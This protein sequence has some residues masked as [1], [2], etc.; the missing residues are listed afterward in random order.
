V[1]TD[2][3]VAGAA[4]KPQRCASELH[5]PYVA[6][7]TTF[8]FTLTVTDG[9]GARA[10]DSVAITVEPQSNPCDTRPPLLTNRHDGRR[11]ARVSRPNETASVYFRVIGVGTLESGGIPTSDWQIYL[12]LEC[13]VVVRSE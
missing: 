11:G 1:G 9:Y 6:A 7:P 13:Q 3:R 5:R 10:S 4:Q 8:E 2:L 12:T